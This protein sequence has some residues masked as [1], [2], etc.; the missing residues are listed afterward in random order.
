MGNLASRARTAACFVAACLISV[1]A[2]ALPPR[3]PNANELLLRARTL[4][5]APSRRGAA[6][7]HGQHLLIQYEAGRRSEALAGLRARNVRVLEAVPRNAVSAWVPAGVDPVSSPGV[8]WVG[9][10]AASDKVALR[11]GFRGRKLR[12]LVDVFPDVSQPA[13]LAAVRRAGG[14]EIPNSYLRATTLH[15]EIAASALGALAAQD[16]VSFIY[17]PS[18]AIEKGLPVGSCLG[19]LTQNGAV[20]NYAVSGDGWDGPGLGTAALQ[21]FFDNGT[22]DLPNEQNEVARALSTWSQF[23]AISWTPV[24]SARQPRTVDFLWATG[25]HGDGE[26]FDGPGQVLAHASLPSPPN[27]EPE[28]GDVHFDDDEVWRVGA[29]VDIYTV[30]LHEI[31]HALG[32]AHSADPSAVMYAY[33]SGPVAGL[34]SDDVAAIRSVYERVGGSPGDAYEPDDTPSEARDLGPPE[35]HSIAP[36]SDVDF[37]KFTLA[38]PADVT[39]AASASTAGDDTL[40][41]LFDAQGGVLET[42]DDF[43]GTKH[44][45]IVRSRADGDPLPSGTYF[46]AVEESGRDAEIGAYEVRLQTVPY[47][48]PDAYE[49]DNSLAQAIPLANSPSWRVQTLS[50]A[51]DKDY[52]VFTLD[53]LSEVWLEA[54]GS[55]GYTNEIEMWLLASDGSVI[56]QSGAQL[57]PSAARIDRTRVDGDWLT[58]GT[59]YVVLSEKGDDAE[60]DYTVRLETRGIPYNGDDP[61]EENDSLAT[62]W[63]FSGWDWWSFAFVRGY[64]YQFDDDYYQFYVARDRRHVTVACGPITPEPLLSIRILD[65]AGNVIHSSMGRPFDRFDNALPRSGTYFLHAFGLDSGAAYDCSWSAMWARPVEPPENDDFADRAPVPQMWETISHDNYLATKEPGEPWHAGE[66]GGGSAWW[67]WTAPNSGEFRVSTLDAYQ[68]LDTLLAVYR[69]D[70]LDALRLVAENDNHQGAL[71]SHVVFQAAANETFAIAVDGFAGAK[72]RYSMVIQEVPSPPPPEEPPPPP[73]SPTSP[74]QISWSTFASKC[75]ASGACKVKAK[76]FAQN[77]D[78]SPTTLQVNVLQS[79][80]TDPGPDDALIRVVHIPILGAGAT[81]T[82]KLKLP[83]AAG[84]APKGKYLIAVAVSDG[85]THSAVYGPLR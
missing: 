25:N 38:T 23:A 32:L 30:A 43:G 16:E 82:L 48:A 60:I 17:A 67:S 4:E 50:P 12:V 53:Q 81:Q 73:P 79:S 69:G 36:A 29:D 19:A 47:P 18:V 63:D 56:E 35:M 78:D 24:G 14:R 15:V 3:V 46:V 57:G 5:P 68:Y 13:A 9:P 72:N 6:A 41:T 71:G 39:I 54:H 84:L 44:A 8:R 51:G 76:V 80:D 74:V 28:A 70:Q 33:Y 65:A 34:A 62:A 20:P 37:T 42:N 40:L 52:S 1:A 77:P 58:A 21:Y 49:P 31:G 7:K 64:G 55:V 45:T 26:P 85:G 27:A 75:K 83:L 59:Y 2:L 11:A 61:F 22:P 10:L 66:A